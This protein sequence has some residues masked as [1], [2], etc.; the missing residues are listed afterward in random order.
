MAQSR[1][2]TYQFLGIRVQPLTT[3][4]LLGVIESAIDSNAENCIIGN[5][6][7]HS[8]YLF[9][10]DAKMRQFYAS[11]RY[12]HVD[13]MSLIFLA[14]ML[15][16]PLNRS[17]RNACLD[18]FEEFFQIAEKNSWRIYF[19]GGRPEVAAGIPARLHRDYPNLQIKTHHGYD[20]FSPKTSV[21]AE[22]EA[23][24]PHIVLV[25]MGM[26]LQER[27]ILEA[28]NRVHAKLFYSCGAIMDYFMGAQKTPPRWL[29]KLGLEWLYRLVHDPAR[30]F[31][32]YVIEPLTLMPLFFC[33]W[34]GR[35]HFA[36]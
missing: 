15:H 20:A 2:P 11:N 9:H 25:G 21:Y 22:I 32:R 33:E 16:I 26:P 4:D 31:F 18:W 7:L 36:G 35:K 13:G 1:F 14:R 8:L 6:N 24:A 5:H 3:S 34:W 23:F 28:Q 17:H 27:W 30:L 10:R 12:T 19:L 29:G